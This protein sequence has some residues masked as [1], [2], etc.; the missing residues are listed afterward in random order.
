MYTIE[1][2][3]SYEEDFEYKIEKDEKA[4][5]IEGSVKTDSKELTKKDISLNVKNK[6]IKVTTDYTEG[7]KGFGQGYLVNNIESIEIDLEEIGLRA[8]AGTLD[9]KVL[10]ENKT[11][12]DISKPVKVS[13]KKIS[14]ELQNVTI[15]IT[16]AGNT[17]III[18]QMKDIP[19]ISIKKGESK[20]L[21]LSE[22]FASN[23][24]ISYSV[25]EPAEINM[26][27]NKDILEIIPDS[28]FTGT[29]TAKIIPQ[30]E[31]T[32]VESNMFNILVSN[33]NISV[34]IEQHRAVIGKP[35]KW[36]KSIKLDKP[37]NITI[38]IPKDSENI[39]VKKIESTGEK[40][41]KVEVRE[42]VLTGKVSLVVNIDKK[43]S[44]LVS[45]FK[46]LFNKMRLTGSV[47]ENATIE[48][49]VSEEVKDVEIEDNGTEY[50]VE[51][52][53]PA[54]EAVERKLGK[55]RKEVKVIG[56]DSVHY[57]DILTYTF[58]D[59]QVSVENSDKIKL[60][61]Y[62]EVEVNGSVINEKT[63]HNFSSFDL[64]ENGYVDYL[65]WITPE[66]SS[67]TF[68]VIIEIT[69]AEHLDENRSFIEDVYEEVSVLD[70]NK[71]IIPS[72]H[73]IRVTFE[74]NL[75]S[76]RDITL[77]AES[78]NE[79][80]VVKVYKSDTEELVT[81]F[82]IGEFG[83]YK[84]YLTEMS[85]EEDVFDLLSFGDVEYDY[86]VDP[87]TETSLNY[88]YDLADIEIGHDPVIQIDEIGGQM[89]WDISSIPSGA[90]INN[91]TLCLYIDSVTG[92]PDDD[93][94]IWYINNE[95]WD[96][97]I[98]AAGAEAQTKLNET[99]E[100]LS[101]NTAETWSCFPV[102]T[103]L[104]ESS[105][106]GNSNFTIR[107]EDPDNLIPD[108][109]VATDDQGFR[110]GDQTG[111][112]YL[113]FEDRENSFSSGNQPYLDITYT[114]GEEE[115]DSDSPAIDF[116]S[117]TPAND[118]TTSNTSIEVNITINESDLN[119]I[120]YNWN[121]TNYTYYDGSLVL[122]LGFDIYSNLTDLSSY[123]NNGTASGAVHNVSGGK[124]GESY[125]FDGD[126]DYIEIADDD[127]L[128]GMDELSIS[129]WVHAYG[130]DDFAGIISKMNES[131]SNA[132]RQYLILFNSDADQKI[133]API[134]ATGGRTSP[135]PISD[136]AFPLN[137]WR[138]ITLTYN[139]SDAILYIDAIAQ[140]TTGTTSGAVD[141]YPNPLF[142]GAQ[143]LVSGTQVDFN[144][145]IDEVRIY[146]RTLSAD[147]IS[148]LYLSNL[149]KYDTDKF[150]LYINQS[151]NSTD[152][153][154]EG[155]YTY[156]GWADDNT[157][158]SNITEIRT[159]EVSIDSTNP[160]VT[161]DTPSN[162]SYSYTTLIV[163]VN[164]TIN[165]EGYCEWSNDSGV[166]NY[167]MT[168]NT[169][170]TRFNATIDVS[171]GNSY[172]INAYCND[173]N[174][175][176]N[177][178]ELV[179]FEVNS[180]PEITIDMNYP[181][182]NISVN[183]NQFFNVSTEV[184]CR[185]ADCGEINVSLDPEGTTTSLN[186]SYD[187]ADLY[188]P[189][190]VTPSTTMSQMKWDISSIPADSTITNATLCL[191]NNKTWSDVDNDINV[192]YI[193]NQTWNETTNSTFL[194]AMSKLNE[195]TEILSSN[196]SLTWTCF[197]VTTQLQESS[198]QGNSNFTIRFE[199]PDNALES[200]GTPVDD[201]GLI[202]GASAGTGYM[203]IEDRE[204][205]L[206]TGNQPYLNITYTSGKTGLIST[207]TGETP[208]YTNMSNP[209]ISNLNQ[210]VCVN[211]TW[212]VNA[213]GTA[214]TNHTFFVYANKTSDESISNIT[215][216][217][218]VTITSDTTKPY[219]T[220]IRNISVFSNQSV[221]VD[222]NATDETAFDCFS[223]NDTSIFSINCSGYIQNTS[224]MSIGT[225]NLN[226]TINDTSNNI[227]SSVFFIEVNDSDSTNPEVTIDTPSNTS[228]N[229]TT[230]IVDVN[231]TINEEGYCE[232]SNDS[233]VN[234]YTM[235]AN[236]SNT[237]FNATIDV[238][239]GNSYTINAYCNDTNGNNNY[240]ELVIF[241]VNSTPAIN[242]DLITPE[243]LDGRSITQYDW[244][245]VSVNVSCDAGGG[246]CGEINVSLDPSTDLH[247]NYSYIL[248]DL[249]FYAGATPTAFSSQLKWN[250]NS[251]ILPSGVTIDNATIC[252]WID[253]VTGS[254]DNDVT[255]WYI[256]NESWKDGLSTSELEAQTKLNETNKTLSSISDDSWTC[257]EITAQLQ[258][259]YANSNENFTL[260]FEDTDYQ[261]KG[262]SI[263][264]TFPNNFYEFGSQAN[265]TKFIFEG[266]SNVLDT[267]NRPYMNITYT[268]SK[269]LIPMNSGTPFYTNVTNPYNVSLNAGESHSI[270]W[271]VNATG[272]ANTNH[273]FFVYA[274]K[275]SDESISNITGTW[276][277]TITSDTTKPYFTYIRNISVFSNQSVNVDFNATDETAFDCFSLNDTSIF[278]INCSGYIQNTSTMSIGTYNLNVT[279]N[280]TNNNINSSLFFIE[281]NESDLTKPFMNI[282]YPENRT[283][284]ENISQLN[285]TF[286]EDN[287]DSCW[288][289]NS[290]GS[291]NSSIVNMGNNFTNVQSD[292]G[293]NTYTLYCNDS[294][295][296]INSTSVTFFKDT[297]T[298]SIYFAN[299]STNASTLSQDYIY[300]N[301]SAS[302]GGYGDRDVSAFVDFN[303]SLK[304]WWRMDD[305]DGVK[306]NDYTGKNNGTGI[307]ATQEEGVIGDAMYFNGTSYI[308]IENSD[309]LEIKENLS[310]S[311][312]AK[313]DSY[314]SDGFMGIIG[315]GGW[316]VG[317]GFEILIRKEGG[318][319]SNKLHLGSRNSRVTSTSE[320]P[321]D[322]WVHIVITISE[323]DGTIYLDGIKD[324]SDSIRS[325]TSNTRNLTIGRRDPGNKFVEYFNG[326]ID[327]ILIFDRALSLEEVKGLY[328]NTSSKYV[329]EN[330]TELNNG[331]YTVTA[332][333][334]DDVGNINSTERTIILDTISPELTIIS[335]E[336]K[337]YITN[338]TEFNVSINEA[339][340]L[341]WYSLDSGQ[342]NITMNEVNSTYFNHSQELAED[343]YTVNF[344]CN[345]SVDNIGTASREFAIDITPPMINLEHPLTH[346]YL[347][348]PSVEFNYTPYPD[349]GSLDVCEL[350]GD[351]SSGWHK[352]K[353]EISPENDTT[354]N[355]SIIINSNGTYKWNIWCNDSLG[356]GDWSVQGNQTFAIDTISPELTIISPENITYPIS[357]IDINISL[358]ETG[359]TCV[360][361]F[362]NWSNNYS[363]TKKTNTSF[364]S[365]KTL[366]DDDY[367]AEF[368]CN[369]S[370]GNVNNTDS[371][372]FL[373]STSG[374]LTIT[375][376]LNITYEENVTEM[377]Y[378]VGFIQSDSCWYSTNS[379]T[380][381]SSIQSP[382]QGNFSGLT[383]GEGGHTWT[384]Y[385]NNSD[386]DENSS[387]VIFTV[388]YPD[389]TKPYFTYIPGNA[390]S[391]YLTE[392]L[393]VDFN[394]TDET[395]FDCF[396]VNDSTNFNINCSGWLRNDTTL[397]VGTYKLNI[398]INDSSNNINSTIYQVDVDDTILPYFTYIRN[399]SVFSNQS[400]NVDFNAID[401]GVGFDCFSLNDTSIFSI[402]CSGYISNTST[403]SIGTYNLN[404]T[405]NDTSNNINSSL[406]YIEVND[407]DL[408]NPSVT[409][410]TTTP[411]NNSEFSPTQRYE[412]NATITD[413]TSLDTIKF[414]FDGTN[415][416]P[417]NVVGN[418]YNWSIDNLQVGTYQYIWWVNDSSNNI[419][420]T[421]TGSY[422][423]TQ[424]SSYS[425][426]ITF[427]S[428]NNETYN[429]STTATGTGCP[430]QLTC[431]LS[432]N[433]SNVGNPETIVLGAGNHNYTYNTTGNTNYSLSSISKLLTINQATPSLT[434]DI[435]NSTYPNNATINASETNTGDSDLNYTL[436][437]NNTGE[438]EGSEIDLSKQLGVATYNITYN[439]TGG[440]N[441][442]SALIS[443]LLKVSIGTG[444][445]YMFVNET[446]GNF[447]ATNNSL[448]GR[449]NV[450]LTS[451]LSNGDGN[452][453][454]YINGTLNA[455]GASPLEILRNLSIGNYNITGNYSGN[456]NYSGD[457][458]VWGVNITESVVVDNTKPVLTIISPINS[459]YTTTNIEFN[460]SLNEEGSSC[461]FNLDNNSYSD[462]SIP[463]NYIINWTNMTK[464]NA[465]W[466]N[467]T[468][469]LTETNHTIIFNCTDT[470]ENEN[471][472]SKRYFD[473]NTSSGDSSGPLIDL[474]SP[475]DDYSEETSSG[476]KN[477]NFEFN[478]SDSSSVATCSVVW[479][480]AYRSTSTDINKS[481]TNTIV[482]SGVSGTKVWS[483]NC[484]D[485][486]NNEGT[487]LTRTLTI[488][489][490]SGDD[491]G[492]GCFLAG[493]KILTVI[494]EKNIEDLKI[495]EEIISY[496]LE[497]KEKVFGKVKEKYFLN[498][499]GYYI[500][501]NNIKVTG[502]H[503]FFVNGRWVEVENL[504]IGDK[505]FN[506][507]EEVEIESIKYAKEN[508]KVYNLQV[509]SE[510]N[511]F[512]NN[513]L[514]HNKGGIPDETC[515]DK[516]SI[517]G[518]TKC[519][520]NVTK[521]TC[522]MGSE[523]CLEWDI[524]SCD[525]LCE[526]GICINENC[527]PIWSC[528]STGCDGEEYNVTVC[529][530]ISD[531]GYG[532]TAN[533]E[534]CDY[535]CLAKDYVC[536]EWGECNA[537]WELI[538][539]VKGETEFSSMI[540]RECS[541]PNSHCVPIVEREECKET[542]DIG[543]RNDWCGSKYLILK[544]SQQDLVRINLDEFKET[545]KM[546]IEM[547]SGG[548]PEYCS[549]CYDNIKNYDEQEI[550]CGGPSCPA[551]K[552]EVKP[553]AKVPLV[554]ITLFLLTL[555]T[556]VVMIIEKKL[557]ERK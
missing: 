108:V 4:E 155:T 113:S 243:D 351:W 384:V 271:Y 100:T 217:W 507:Q 277:V 467:F 295:N 232:W 163:E 226:V 538:D 527:T 248:E 472:T 35:V 144:G 501:N 423:I 554:L 77:Y 401:D 464:F 48:Q 16:K 99:T 490:T 509:D 49:E 40:E 545:G 162:T 311:V 65:E 218:N 8:E 84:N 415:Y 122:H 317:S 167:T 64:S 463:P 116:D 239:S 79:S 350:W 429:T 369:D 483:V 13:E 499:E 459:T 371:V 73:Y 252:F 282:E 505:M 520:N 529:E 128:K 504:K 112:T 393:A 228:Y 3:V 535:G 396:E 315:K 14:E 449:D 492:G 465:T 191:Y 557:E 433:L 455:S 188:L 363:L 341:C 308:D 245:N 443:K 430:S 288:Y 297:I 101:S 333:S 129:L 338:L 225:Y 227:N 164:F 327:D 206:S 473:V 160:E 286:T 62:K 268:T 408:T 439:T 57:R 193:N 296:N 230:L 55:G 236:T 111:T 269:G 555:I 231:F 386:G 233:G 447:T 411:S 118:T 422:V 127:T 21:N 460:V 276:N 506:G 136:A 537:N 485:T 69:R 434:L 262:D 342:T 391:E 25:T 36:K 383:S 548:F 335:P 432:R 68:E 166:N 556:Y 489:E 496:D 119:S 263:E 289:S 7:E 420:N 131:D 170:N 31:N 486:S 177:Y 491:N 528:E 88:S 192:S 418:I 301:V 95:T 462:G 313:L 352:N 54:P 63:E 109:E 361:T 157:G 187:L 521:A 413:E 244:F 82:E 454:I 203:E 546:N 254:P 450:N 525:Y 104:Q 85:G 105:S 419:N 89:K 23:K 209:N 139:G 332:Y 553:R 205:S 334:Q 346:T 30:V 238:S 199:D 32:T 222:F 137:Q 543:I 395:S 114:G 531:C 336:A 365:K 438:D 51:Y 451:L 174:G 260:R 117:L 121:G 78:I 309:S 90:T 458:E 437:I 466:F 66:L 353:T 190:I 375:Y 37:E 457:N 424:N 110:I 380:D 476:S 344:W 212:Y 53:T 312:W 409:G 471:V 426:D 261:I 456:T 310:V 477:I 331:T 125:Y 524:S 41:A 204:N 320:F 444:E 410:L 156:Y 518:E 107:F 321:L 142:I 12:A 6:K 425:L 442:S 452:I 34:S 159:L 366:V 414:Q 264:D 180:T 362:D 216:T 70:G 130:K 211:V 1:G 91:A 440:T 539:I 83:K 47:I 403:M 343:S 329:Q 97:S 152:V 354:N 381:N 220:Y 480:G 323:T 138:Y 291:G 318:S 198:S 428:S 266:A 81:E 258:Q 494:G 349:G 247:L 9:L 272:T 240:S 475:A 148:Q 356:T 322:Q 183:Q 330:F 74:Q 372:R 534:K 39:T 498:R 200:A 421:E 522:K 60:Y 171:S 189:Q 2:E 20:I 307:G 324:T 5:I 29:K 145:S 124:Y 367:L 302:D 42:G 446:R 407:S 517:E 71:T 358:D 219:F 402:N 516:C 61:W 389:N 523:G 161:I 265:S 96:E 400:V 314:N 250:I 26:N 513:I 86:I 484:T 376:P 154:D 270:T 508:I 550:D 151:K 478:V 153:L 213:T 58:I 461:K 201:S 207:I 394:A 495:G 202:I 441:Y 168:A 214:N 357:Q 208:F 46:N 44:G 540:E 94:R 235:T 186:Y 210:D 267:G 549:Y 298:P 176:N 158:N 388:E 141:S 33:A 75:S 255:T 285:Y 348:S 10:Y 515:E 56:P 544:N 547:H 280:D 339:T 253:S 469:T 115:G 281:V 237:R 404:V 427:T 196:T 337:T 374:N 22:Y 355:F 43:E 326:S 385:C 279:I 102:T 325:L 417:Q 406:F 27:I 15:N 304:A 134:F 80:S 249:Y 416:T 387:S 390:T 143:N 552:E 185:N 256:N 18:R 275:T 194:V 17:S 38:K 468:H 474:Q 370:A 229:Y 445:I 519:T 405:I 50:E 364:Y 165:E 283:Y 274:N 19:D 481:S 224:T 533:R 103:Q 195:T 435:T 502:E 373:V 503:P 488:S 526:N 482:A 133:Y 242:L 67:Q 135:D 87:S 284:N 278:S 487:S 173:T 215:G 290:S 511:Y 368:W 392:N 120:I 184:C 150:S 379:G 149:R 132:N 178:S 182:T 299:P 360:Y 179:I 453:E 345:D 292:E 52:E 398:T 126:D 172:T 259:A 382:P 500:I 448:Y 223:L 221:N 303:N 146:N 181:T 479:G 542:V 76:D 273:T 59:E 92:T 106:Q 431:N 234:N 493:T 294:S 399:I 347:D 305:L 512:A 140:S 541:H 497:N 123:G 251:S 532:T 241:E 412:F 257:F 536:E 246:N 359:D 300:M 510:K 340:S 293:S 551:C 397:S 24:S 530:D 98:S 316:D 436:Y 11:L 287:P 319:F 377:N 514:V 175:N 470:S 45:F 169:S 306:V 197:P 28:N 147:E 72:G 378:S 328:A 93:I